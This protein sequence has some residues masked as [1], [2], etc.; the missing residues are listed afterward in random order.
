VLAYRIGVDSPGP[1]PKFGLFIPPFG[2]LSDPR[3]LMSLATRAEGAGWDGIFLWDH[4]LH[5]DGVPIGEV[6]VMLTAIA[7]VTE[8][9]RLGPM[10]T[11]LSR[12]RPWVVARQ[13][14]TLDHLSGGR[15]VLG[16]GSGGDGWREFSA[17]GEAPDPAIRGQV[18]DESLAVI[19]RLWSGKPAS[20]AGAHFTVDRA[21]VLPVPVQSPRIPI[22]IA[23]MW[24]NAA[25]LRRAAHWDGVFPIG[26]HRE[27]E[28]GD[29]AGLVESMP[30]DRRFDVVLQGRRG[31]AWPSAARS[32]LAGLAAAGLTWWLEAVDHRDAGSDVDR[33]VD[34]GPPR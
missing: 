32:E 2:A 22:W 31:P 1:G 19:T 18:V 27:L 24:P 6:W 12:R 3:R 13:A 10:V 5:G 7:A 34:A 33:L 20:F 14:V 23:A 16:V 21:H 30:R 4:V 11:P 29:L 15:V 26:R 9:I 28:A 8:R 25:P 17:F